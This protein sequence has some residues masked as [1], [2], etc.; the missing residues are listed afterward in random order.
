MTERN[1][2]T[3]VG[4]KLMIGRSRLT[5]SA[6]LLSILSFFLSSLMGTLGSAI[7]GFIMGQSCSAVVLGA[8]SLSSPIWFA[9]SIIYQV[10]AMGCQPL[11]S[12]ELTG[13]DVD[14][15]RRIYS[16]S[17]MVCIGISMLATVLIIVFSD[18]MAR[19]L[20]AVP[21]SEIYTPCR[22]YLVGSIV[23][24]PGAAMIAMLSVGINIEGARK[25]SFVSTLV[26]TVS[27]IL[28]DLI[29][30]RFFNASPFV[31]GLTTS[32]SYFLGALV[33]IIYYLRRKDALLRPRWCKI[34]P[35][36][37]G[38]VAYRG[39]PIGVSRFTCF[40]R[41]K[42]LNG[43]LAGAVTAYGLAAYN[44]QVQINYLTNAVFMGIAQT[45]AMMVSLYYAEK[46]H[47]S[48]WYVTLMSLVLEAAIGGLCMWLG[49][50]DSAILTLAQVY[51]GGNVESYDIAGIAFTLFMRG[52]IGQALTILFANYLSSTRRTILSN[53]VYCISDLVLFPILLTMTQTSYLSAHQ[54]AGNE[55]V[56]MTLPFLS[57][58]RA[59]M[60]MLIVIPLIILFT[61]L[62]VN[63]RWRSMVWN[64]LVVSLMAASFAVYRYTTGTGSVISETERVALTVAAFLLLIINLWIH[65][66]TISP[67]SFLLMLPAD[68]GVSPNQEL[69]CAP[70]TLDEVNAFS[71][72]VYDFCLRNGAGR[73][74]AYVIS[75]AAEEI[76]NNII[77]HGFRNRRRGGEI[78]MRMV[79]KD[80]Q[81]VL[82]VRDN[83]VLFD[84]TEYMPEISDDVSPES[85]IGIRMIRELASEIVYTSTLKMN[86]LSLVL[87]LPDQSSPSSALV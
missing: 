52:M 40:F 80:Q 1:R 24:V 28:M 32:I 25:W 68:F 53:A 18:S 45:L 69:T 2:N 67:I 17:I 31:M 33:L 29:C 47:K 26:M 57:L 10:L 65:R 41:S 44:M 56:L 64:G 9:S 84:P 23:S 66:G 82:R 35:R 76:G 58:Y 48:I 38:R 46:N 30:V 12:Q 54:A 50:S 6:F 15:S 13:G 8:V 62:A 74:K 51:L 37:I 20:G 61:C 34:E 16:M 63:R 49:D 71:R 4:H 70:G 22:E 11:C 85:H 55:T 79:C 7:D 75:L 83:G 73:R 60:I 27:N 19:F 87:E 3:T 42:L 39:L 5:R 86:N 36:V 14:R 81:L 77:R 43:A 21:G 72:R 78:E 59:Q